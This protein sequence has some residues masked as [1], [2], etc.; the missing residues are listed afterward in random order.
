MERLFAADFGDVRL[1]TGRDATG[2]ADDIDAAAYTVGHHI[3][4]G[5]GQGTHDRAT[6]E[7]LLA[8]ELA[9]V[10]QQ[11]NASGHSET[12][13]L[14]D[15]AALEG[16]AD[17]AAQA[18]AHG[19]R[20]P[21]PGTAPAGAAVVQRQPKS[22]T[23]APPAGGNVFYV[24]MNNFAPEVAALRKLFKGTALGLTAV[25]LTQEESKTKTTA[26]GNTAFDLTTDTGIDDFAKALGLDTTKTKEVAALLKGQSD[27]YDRDDMAHVIAVYAATELDG[28]DRLS[29]VILS[30]HSRGDSVFAKGNKGDIYFSFLVSL[31]S[32]FPKAAGQTKHLMGAAC[33]AGEEDSVLNLYKPAFPNLVTYA[34]WTDF[35]PTGSEGVDKM[36]KWVKDTNVD[37]KTLPKP[38]PGEA[39][40]VSGTY[41]GAFKQRSPTETMD[42]LRFQEQ[43]IF[44]DF[45]SGKRS[46][47]NTVKGDIVDYYVLANSAAHRT[48]TITGADHDYAQ[49]HADQAFRLRFWQTMVANFWHTYQTQIKKGYG[50]AATPNYGKMSRKDALQAIADF[51]K[52]A[53]GSTDEKAEAEKLLDALKNLDP[54]VL[55]DGWIA[56]P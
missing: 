36:R 45:F 14:V 35:S 29:R 37:P 48:L 40:W 7:R 44:D 51:P 53:Q 42:S 43:T 19:R 52:A 47:T 9:H 55:K 31:A 28:K 22:K 25:T 49:L 32:I 56:M 11:R 23:P 18:A 5:S 21:F 50:S 16:G 38:G 8:H 27:L 3:V 46:V 24:G 41:Q 12:A 1:H 34:G 4:L 54:T 30:G 33:F 15:D 10:V 17:A 26:T 20:V 2:S 13:R 6:T 39:T